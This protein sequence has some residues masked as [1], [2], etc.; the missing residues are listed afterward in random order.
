MSAD[1]REGWDTYYMRIANEVKTRSTCTRRQVGAVAVDTRHRVITTGYNGAPSGMEHC[2]H[3]SCVRRRMNIPSGQQLDL[4]KAIH[5]EGNI[6][7]EAGSRLKESTIY[8]T[9]QPCTSC[10]KLLFGAGVNRIVWQEFY[11]DPYA[12]T[13]MLEWGIPVVKHGLIQ[14]L[15]KQFILDKYEMPS[16]AIPL[17]CNV[18]NFTRSHLEVSLTE[19]TRN[20]IEG[21]SEFR[22]TD[23]GRKLPSN[24]W[25]WFLVFDD[26]KNILT[27]QVANEVPNDVRTSLIS[28]SE[29]PI[30]SNWLTELANKKL[31]DMNPHR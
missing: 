24:T 4:C 1:T 10:F 18:V 9:N 11:P 6:V 16:N 30:A 2:T 22:K 15:S 13:L 3:D 8:C 21:Y 20:V 31:A 26:V 23:E 25:D 7:L 29:T 14:L 27:Q 19:N 5:A 12:S 17:I 28:G